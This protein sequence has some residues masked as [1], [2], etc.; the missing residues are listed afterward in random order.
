MK[1]QHYH[2][3]E[4]T[5]AAAVFQ[6]QHGC[7]KAKCCSGEKSFADITEHKVAVK[8]NNQHLPS[9]SNLISEYATCVTVVV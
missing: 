9:K 7:R 1:Q 5:E 2:Q 6:K 4:R 3:Q 8:E